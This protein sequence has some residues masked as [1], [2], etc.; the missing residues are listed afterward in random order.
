MAETLEAWLAAAAPFEKSKKLAAN[1]Y[2][3]NDDG[4]TTFKTKLKAYKTDKEGNIIPR[5][6]PVVG[7]DKTPVTQTVGGGS[8][9]NVALSL[10]PWFTAGLGFGIQLRLK[11]V[12]VLTLVESAYDPLNSFEAELVE[13]AEDF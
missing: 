2:Q 7:P 5:K 13:G 10:W 4:T 8:I 1:P 3:V 9:A 12:Q 11:A 6:L